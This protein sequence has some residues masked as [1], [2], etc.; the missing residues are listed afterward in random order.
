MKYTKQQ[1]IDAI[2]QHPELAAM[3]ALSATELEIVRGYKTVTTSEL[4]AKY[5]SASNGCRFMRKL[6][7]KGY[8]KRVKAGVFTKIGE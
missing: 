8:F 1:A 7:S 3:M 2:R 4:E 6:I 5:S